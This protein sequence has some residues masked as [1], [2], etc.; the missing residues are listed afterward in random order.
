[1]AVVVKSVESVLQ[2]GGFTGFHRRVVLITGLA[3]TFVAMEILL[4]SF[5]LPLFANLWNLTGASLGLIGAAAL[6]GSFVGSLAGGRLADRRGRRLVFQVSVLW[7][8]VFTALTAA[9]WDPAS[10]FA[11]RFLAG[12]GLGGMLVVD[13]SV[14]S[15]Y[16]PPQS[17]GRFMVFLDFFWPIG[18]LIALGL[19]FYFLEVL[20]GQWRL[21]FLVAAFPAFVAFLIRRLVPETPYYLARSGRLQ[22]AAGVLSQV[23]G[24]RVDPATVE[25]VK[26]PVRAPAGDLFRGRLLRATVVTLAAWIALNFSYYGFFIWLPGAL[27][28]VKGVEVGNI[29]TLLLL[30]VLA[31]FPGYLSAMWLVE[32]WGRKRT[33]ATFLIL[34]GLSG[35]VFATATDYPSFIA[36]LFFVSFFNL[37]AWGSVYPYTVELFP[38][39]LRGTAFGLAA[40]GAGKLTAILGPAVFGYLKDATVGVIVPLAVVAVVMTVGGLVVAALGQETKGVPME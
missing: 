31:Q 3:W 7:Y 38:T 29:Y 4:I 17:R 13:P 2:E 19:A 30:S 27:A 5:T 14:L 11:F 33:L 15:E 37:G 39:L 28:E 8:S 40:E 21:L 16:L 6:I 34:G 25:A 36:G 12:L 24:T 10:L 1:M 20:G 9:A 22:E 32:A 26:G 18:N 35:V 23:T